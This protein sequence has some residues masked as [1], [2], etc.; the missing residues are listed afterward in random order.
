M[1][2]SKYVTRTDPPRGRRAGKGHKKMFSKTADRT[3]KMNVRIGP[4]VNR[5]G[6][7]L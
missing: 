6:R 3:D 7:R 1:S 5:G 4:P 2:N